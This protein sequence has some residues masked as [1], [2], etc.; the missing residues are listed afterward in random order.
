VINEQ[1]YPTLFGTTEVA[2]APIDVHF[3]LLTGEI[4][5]TLVA[6]VYV[7]PFVGDACV[8]VGFD[9]DGGDWGPAGGP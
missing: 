1:D 7:V 3:L 6:R 4:D 5:P 9:T 8:V 2:W